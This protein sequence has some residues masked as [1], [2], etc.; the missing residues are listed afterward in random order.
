MCNSSEWSNL[1]QNLI[2]FLLRNLV[3]NKMQISIFHVL[4]QKF[5]FTRDLPSVSI[6]PSLFLVD[7]SAPMKLIYC[8]ASRH[9]VSRN[10]SAVILW[11]I[12]FVR[13]PEMLI[14]VHMYASYGLRT[15]RPL[16][17]WPFVMRAVSLL[18]RITIMPGRLEYLWLL[19]SAL[20]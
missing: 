3:T 7:L 8:Y 16:Y 4:R 20:S 14:Y 19:H 12:P 18:P 5:P 1:A 17:C 11:C 13:W 15:H 9:Q 10:Q 2:S 6:S